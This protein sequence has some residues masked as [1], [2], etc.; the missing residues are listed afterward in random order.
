MQPHVMKKIALSLFVI[1]FSLECAFAQSK[2]YSFKVGYNV[3]C[4]V[5]KKSIV[6]GSDF[7]IIDDNGDTVVKGMVKSVAPLL[8]VEGDYYTSE[9][10]QSMMISGDFFV[11]NSLDGSFTL[12]GRKGELLNI[13]PQEVRYV[14]FQ[15]EKKEVSFSDPDEVS[16]LMTIKWAPPTSASARYIKTTL[17]VR[18]QK[19]LFDR[20]GYTDID[21]LQE[22]T[23]SGYEFMWTG[24]KSFSGDIYCHLEED[25]SFYKFGLGKYSYPDLVET[26]TNS[27]EAGYYTYVREV[28]ND[29]D[30]PI[31]KMIITFPESVISEMGYWDVVAMISQG[32][33]GEFFFNDGNSFKGEY[34]ALV[35]NG[36]ITTISYGRGIYR[37][38]SGDVF[39]GDFSGRFVG[40][41]PI[42][43]QLTLSTGQTPMDNWWEKYKL[44]QDNWKV[45]EQFS[46]PTEKFAYAIS[47]FTADIINEKIEII[48]NHLAAKKNDE[49]LEVLKE[50]EEIALTTT[51]KEEWIRLKKE[52]INDRFDRIFTLLVQGN[53]VKAAN[54][55]KETE[56]LK[57]AYGGDK[58][59]RGE[60]SYGA[61]LNQHHGT[62]NYNYRLAS[63]GLS[64]IYDGSFDYSDGYLSVSGFF[65]NGKR[66]GEWIAIDRSGD[67]YEVFFAVYNQ[68]RHDGTLR[69]ARVYNGKEVTYYYINEFTDGK[70]DGTYRTGDDRTDIVGEYR[71]GTPVGLWK[72]T[73]KRN[74]PLFYR[75]DVSDTHYADFSKSK[76][77]P[78]LYGFNEG[79][80]QKYEIEVIINES[81]KIDYMGLLRFEENLP[82][83]DNSYN[84]ITPVV[85][86]K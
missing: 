6:E 84:K 43:G 34:S 32:E 78:D 64:R 62:V 73:F 20:Y 35:Q 72:Q 23:L 26:M 75:S 14:F 80:G 1:V 77:N 86:Q 85:V 39:E 19:S 24:G 79:T 25:G 50:Y 29:L 67:S 56:V 70:F 30:A 15:N 40:G 82:G 33:T 10:D 51:A 60:M 81:T 2:T 27:S 57:R 12:N 7:L 74:N 11:V 48:N 65:S 41:V 44:S 37:W 42:D 47:V 28:L 46:T 16:M 4:A 9:G 54:L 69:Y 49:A 18:V 83:P 55:K 63:D 38:Y 61:F 45:F 5:E 59:Y 36:G 71:G 22:N 31:T 8:I 68:G 53:F 58:F 3:T 13:Q 66:D 52:L 76:L 21:A 17:R